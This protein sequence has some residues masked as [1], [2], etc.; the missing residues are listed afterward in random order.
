MTRCA[1]GTPY[2]TDAP[3]YSD[4][5]QRCMQLRKPVVSQRS[6]YLIAVLFAK[7]LTQ[8]IEC[9]L[10][11]RII[12]AL[13]ENPNRRRAA[14]NQTF[15]IFKAHIDKQSPLGRMMEIANRHLS[16]VD[17]HNDHLPEIKRA[18]RL[19]IYVEDV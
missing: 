12:D 15:N 7:I 1:L 14:N 18:A 11:P 19:S 5:N 17:F 9:A 6:T 10:R 16:T 8:K 3:G 13:D 4:Y 2:R